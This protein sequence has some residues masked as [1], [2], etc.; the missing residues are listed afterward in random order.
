MIH[1]MGGLPVGWTRHRLASWV[2]G[3][4]ALV[5]AGCAATTTAATPPAT[6]APT[7]T[8][9]PVATT[10][11]AATSPS[12]TATSTT[13][14]GVTGGAGDTSANP[15]SAFICGATGT[16]GSGDLLAYLTVAGTDAATANS[17]CSSLE[18]ASGWSATSTIPA[19]GYEAAPEC[20]VTYEGGAITA[21]I[22][23]AKGSSDAETKV[24]CN[25][26]LAGSTLPT[27]A[28]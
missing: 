4:V 19:G 18:G 5:A 25:T 26:L 2:L 16:D 20:Y 10:A 27:L 21:R 24:L 3:L 13:V 23:T 14:A 15:D 1:K 17:L 12:A 11:P 7:A 22:Y 8:T 6:V 28:P 9:A